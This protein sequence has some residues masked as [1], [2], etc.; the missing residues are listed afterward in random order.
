MKYVLCPDKARKMLEMCDE[1]NNIYEVTKRFSD[2]SIG[3]SLAQAP[4]PEEAEA[5]ALEW[6]WCKSAVARLIIVD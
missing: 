3:Y 6:S 4:T 2:G 1:G 5:I